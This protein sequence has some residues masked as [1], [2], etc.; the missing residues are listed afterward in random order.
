MGCTFDYPY[1]T[2]LLVI[3]V[4]I[5]LLILFSVTPPNLFSATNKVYFGVFGALPHRQ[6]VN[7]GVVEVCEPG[8]WPL[9]TKPKLVHGLITPRPPWR[10]VV[11]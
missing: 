4:V 8:T 6:R 2:L 3:S 10:N 9:S 11:W 5:L 7:F 1:L